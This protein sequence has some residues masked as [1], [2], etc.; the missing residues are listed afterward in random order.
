MQEA[1]RERVTENP[2]ISVRK[3][4]A[5]LPGT[6]KSSVHRTFH[7][8]KLRAYRVS[9][10]QELKLIDHHR[11]R[12]FCAWFLRLIRPG[13]DILNYV[14]FSDEAWVHLDGY[15]NSQNYR[16]WTSEN[17]NAFIEKGLHPVKIGIWCAISRQRIVGPFFYGNH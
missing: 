2:N 1:V 5:S 13:I 9:V 11:R 6:S 15:V 12:E 10:R 17:P 4:A 3:L 8:L 14:F 16:L 7:D